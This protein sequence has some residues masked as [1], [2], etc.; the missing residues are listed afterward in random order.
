[1]FQPILHCAS[2]AETLCQ[3]NSIQNV[4]ICENIQ[5]QYKLKDWTKNYSKSINQTKYNPFTTCLYKME[6][7]IYPVF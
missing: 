5:V 1:M 2:A 6:L 4:C 7:Y 3:S